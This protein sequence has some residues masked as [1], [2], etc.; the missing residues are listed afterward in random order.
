MNARTISLEADSLYDRYGKPLEQDHRGEYIAIAQDGR[1][2][3]DEDDVKVI[4]QAVDKF[5][6]GNFIF[7][8]VGYSYVDKLRWTHADQ[9]GLS[10]SS[11]K[12]HCWQL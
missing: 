10:V 2:I 1:I 7:R 12:G 4:D 11:S 8:R 5:G 3:V 9:Q 6:S